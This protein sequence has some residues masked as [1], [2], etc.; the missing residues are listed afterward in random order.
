MP[1]AF[2]HR[3]M[4]DI[5]AQSPEVVDKTAVPAK[6]ADPEP[7]LPEKYVGKTVAEI[8]DMHANAEKELGRVRN[9]LGEQRGL[10]ASLS[11]IQRREVEQ[12]AAPQDEVIITG[13]QI[14]SDPVGSVN[15]IIQPHLDAAAHQRTEAAANAQL[16][17]ENAALDND[18]ADYPATVATDEFQK[19]ALRTNSRRA[20]FETAANGEGLKQ[21]RA[22]RRLLEDYKDF[23]DST[24]ESKPKTPEEEGFAA[25]QAA[26]TEV[27]ASSAPISS[28][29]LVYESDAIALLNSNAAK[30]RS[31]SYQTE[32]AA[33]IREGRFVKNT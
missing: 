23:Q 20:D 16:F 27:G 25:G 12:K 8:A 24:K 29:S 10:V 21:V 19:F 1:T 13:D 5:L 22:A 14:L 30:Y 2:K 28:K 17:A 15:R 31:P 32:L 4:S 7:T 11:Q 33:A 6:T 3:P 18:F 9:E 26:I